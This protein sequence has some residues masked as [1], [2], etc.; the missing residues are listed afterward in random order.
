MDSDD[1]HQRSTAYNHNCRMWINQARMSSIVSYFHNILR[2]EKAE[3]KLFSGGINKTYLARRSL[4][5]ADCY[6][7]FYQINEKPEHRPF[8]TQSDIMSSVIWQQE[9]KKLSFL[10]LW[11]VVSWKKKLKDHAALHRGKHKC[12]QYLW[13]KYAMS[14]S[15]CILGP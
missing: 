15:R 14:M 6:I 8:R 13:A 7:L 3:E 11:E 4:L 5:N 10:R 2:R 9:A 1:V 12:D